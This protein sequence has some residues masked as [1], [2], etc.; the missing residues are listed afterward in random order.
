M[1]AE[2]RRS[3]KFI[4]WAIIIFGGNIFFSCQ[5]ENCISVFNNDLILGFKDTTAVGSSNMDFYVDTVFNSI[6]AVGGDTVLYDRTDVASIFPLPVNPSADMTTF[7][8][9]MIDS[10]RYDTLSLDPINIDTIYFV[11]PIPHTITVSYDR[12]KRII[13]EECGVE[14][15]YKNLKIEEI[16]FPSYNL[17]NDKLSRLNEFKDEINIEVLF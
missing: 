7:I 5:D 4:F 13:T 16:S 1:Q 3:Y 14:I 9:E 8:L 11:N 15:A 6:T 12:T 10:I 17:V 2:K